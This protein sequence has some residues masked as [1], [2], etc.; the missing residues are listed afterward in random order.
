[1]KPLTVKDSFVGCRTTP[2][3]GIDIDVPRLK[4]RPYHDRAGK[5]CASTWEEFPRKNYLGTRPTQGTEA[6]DHDDRADMLLAN[7]EISSA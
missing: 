6:A 2:G 4:A 5:G 1:M 3:H 7:R